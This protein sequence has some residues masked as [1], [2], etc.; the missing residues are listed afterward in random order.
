MKRT[1]SRELVGN[2]SMLPPF[3]RVPI[4]IAANRPNA[5]RFL[6]EAHREH[7]RCGT[8]KARPAAVNAECEAWS[9]RKRPETSRQSGLTLTC[10]HIRISIYSFGPA[11][12]GRRLI[13]VAV[14]SCQAACGFWQFSR[15][16]ET[17]QLSGVANFSPAA[18]N[19]TWAGLGIRPRVTPC[20]SEL[21]AKA[22]FRRKARM[23][24]AEGHSG[25]A[26]FGNEG[27]I[28]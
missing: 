4:A 15:R 17:C 12:Q 9:D 22:S 26:R 13:R 28:G 10:L 8:R 6:A 23:A 25:D 20:G 27:L 21:W 14:P 5:G 3:V 19:T 7:P 1:L 24:R 2:A 16:C 11:R 18:C